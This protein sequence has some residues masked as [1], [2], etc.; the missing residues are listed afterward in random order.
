MM[1]PPGTPPGT[2][3]GPETPDSA[4]PP[5]TQVPPA[6][7]SP[8]RRF[9]VPF[10]RNSVIAAVLALF[11]LGAAGLW[12]W[13]KRPRLSE[14]EVRTVVY[15]TIQREAPA[16]FLV[17][18][19]LDITVTTRV[20]NTRTL[21]PGILGLDLGTTTSTVRVPGRVSY[22]FDVRALRPEMIRLLDDG[23][24]EV[25]IP[26]VTVY[27][28][29]PGLEQMEVETRRGW[30]RISEGTTT[31]VRERAM[32]LIMPTMRTQGTEHL[33]SST[34]PRINTAHAL[35][36]MLRSALEAA[37]LKDPEIRFRA[38]GGVTVEPRNRD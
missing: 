26:D 2:P 28:V 35:D 9:S 11:V 38:G 4:E 14:E 33:R 7:A 32:Q 3:P 8:A 37:G 17:T 24:V 21:L 31:Q 36:A 20:E 25:H 22:G 6:D 15:S 18:G 30:A 13:S 34:Q 1:E 12:L 27:S 16:S 23:V 29:E 5:G 10:V 19:T